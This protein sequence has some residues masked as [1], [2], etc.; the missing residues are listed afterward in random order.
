MVTAWICGSAISFS[1]KVDAMFFAASIPWV[2]PNRGCV[3]APHVLKASEALT[4]VTSDAIIVL[5]LVE[6]AHD[7]PASDEPLRL[8]ALFERR[9]FSPQLSPESSQLQA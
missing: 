6:E 5:A 9:L 2:G 8:A 1:M 7:R 3:Y 4:I